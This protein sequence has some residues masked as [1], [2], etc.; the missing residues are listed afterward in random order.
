MLGIGFSI[1]IF[2][3]SA[4]SINNLGIYL[5]R[6]ALYFVQL[7]LSVDRLIVILNTWRC[8]A[9]SSVLLPWQRRLFT[10]FYQ[11]KVVNF[12]IYFRIYYLAIN[13]LHNTFLGVHFCLKFNEYVLWLLL[14][15]WFLLGS[16]WIW[17][18]LQNHYTNGV[19]PAIC[20]TFNSACL[21]CR[22]YS[23]NLGRNF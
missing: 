2:L 1:F 15:A 18:N 21:H 8:P 14:F 6:D 17:G 11:L 20:C 4:V 9:N 22:Q 13:F 10:V 5:S 16:I 3:F 23:V 19:L 7:L 12:Q